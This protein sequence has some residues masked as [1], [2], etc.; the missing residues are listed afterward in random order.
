MLLQRCKRYKQRAFLGYKTLAV[1]LIDMAEVLQQPSEEGRALVLHRALKDAAVPVAEIRVHS[2]SSQPIHP[3]AKGKMADRSPDLD[4]FSEEEEESFSSE[5]EGSDDAIQGQDLFDE[6]EEL[7]KS[8]KAQR[9]LLAAAG[10]QPNIKQKF[11]ALLK[12]FKVSEEAL[13]MDLLSRAVA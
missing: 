4:N 3:E 12:R 7:P 10:R 8:K 11:V 6:E 1:G 13:R 2:L 9:K 5:P